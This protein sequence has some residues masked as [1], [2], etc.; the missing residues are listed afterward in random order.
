MHFS[1]WLQY[2]QLNQNHF[3][4]IN[5]VE[6]SELTKEEKRKI[7]KSLQQFQKGENS[8][9]K[10]LYRFA[11]LMKDE[12][13]LEAIKLFIKEEQTHAGV[14][15]RFM[16]QERIPL[17]K[18]HWVDAVFRRIRTLATLENSVII[19]I[20]AEIIAAVYYQALAV[21]TKSST[22]KS[23]CDQIL[24][25][26]EKHIAF[27][28][29]ALCVFYGKR[30]R[31]GKKYIRTFHSTLMTVTAILVWI[32]HKEVLAEKFSFFSYAK[33]VRAEYKQAALMITGKANTELLP[34]Q[35]ENKTA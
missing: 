35:L 8:E 24:R 10:N 3:S 2:F 25:D 26:E 34:T 12:S 19:L 31:F 21:A 11:R 16:R 7:T 32:H 13:Y 6:Q 28:S 18:K 4:Y 29:R 14:L 5:W 22:L 23:L 1:Q 20:T 17:I 27:Q 30:S 33:A 15:G 9:G